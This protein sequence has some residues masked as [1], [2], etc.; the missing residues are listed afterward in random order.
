MYFLVLAPPASHIPRVQNQRLS[1]LVLTVLWTACSPGV[2]LPV[3]VSMSIRV[4]VRVRVRVSVR[5]RCA[6]PEFVFQLPFGP[7]WTFYL[8]RSAPPRGFPLTGSH[9]AR[10]KLRSLR[11]PECV[12]Q[13][14]TRTEK[15][16]GCEVR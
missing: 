2:N 14:C 16:A 9:A 1:L 4:A 11:I 5:V 7:V 13:L 8:L 3:Q 10:P 6:A 15:R 12:T